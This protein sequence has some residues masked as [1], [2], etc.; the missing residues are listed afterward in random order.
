MFVT[1]L[2]LLLEPTTGEFTFA[3]AGH[4]LPLCS[5]RQGVVELRAT[6]MPLGLLPGMRYSE[7]Q[8]RL[9]PGDRLLL[10]SDG[11]VEA[12]NPHKEM[13]GF[14]YLRELVGDQPLGCNVIEVLMQALADFTGPNWEQEDDV[15]LLTIERDPPD[16]GWKL[17]AEFSL[18]SKPGN[19]RL[20]MARMEEL[21]QGLPFSAAKVERLKTAVGETTMNAME[22]GNQFRAELEAKIQVLVSDTAL[23]VR[24]TDFGGGKQ[25][26]ETVKPDIEAKLAGLQSPRGWGLFLIENMVDEMK[27]QA[28]ETHHTVELI[29]KFEE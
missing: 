16:S 3:N 27:V 11:L 9:E 23:A 6:G 29:M 26:P 10:Y 13:F 5:T 2:F 28:D 17:L 19:E 22:H 4:N 12:H 20:A 8:G 14:P 15:T 1:C 24:I 21:V 25:I 18:P 7:T